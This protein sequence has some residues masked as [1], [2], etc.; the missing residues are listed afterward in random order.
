MPCVRAAHSATRREGDAFVPHD[1]IA[2]KVPSGP[3]GTRTI[4]IRL[5]I[6]W[7]AGV[8]VE[9]W[10]WRWTSA[11]TLISPTNSMQMG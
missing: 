11:V 1:E 7:R 3:G 4:P 9:G 5:G 10:C 8:E 2:Q 6:T